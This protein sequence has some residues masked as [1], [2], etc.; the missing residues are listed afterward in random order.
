VLSNG[1]QQLECDMSKLE[2]INFVAFV[3]TLC[4]VWGGCVAEGAFRVHGSIRLAGVPLRGNCHMK[5]VRADTQE[6]AKDLVVGPAFQETVVV[7]PGSRDYYFMISCPG[8]EDSKTTTYSVTGAQQ[9][10][11]PI[12]LGTITLTPRP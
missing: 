2:K 4:V 10:E 11:K 1:E 7:A 6:V 5:V 8:A 9:Y 12:D 3:V